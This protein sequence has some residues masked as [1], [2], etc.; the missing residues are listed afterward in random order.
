MP[1]EEM[2]RIVLNLVGTVPEE[3]GIK[4]S[5][6]RLHRHHR[7]TQPE[8]IHQGHHRLLA[9]T[10]KDPNVAMEAAGAEAAMVK[11]E[12]EIRLRRVEAVS[13]QGADLSRQTT[14]AIALNQT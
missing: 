6:M 5:I 10:M 8:I 14:L 11:G 4:G 13:L 3:I 2:I 1:Y 7:V 9:V 12:A